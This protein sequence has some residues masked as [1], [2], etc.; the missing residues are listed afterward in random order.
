[1]LIVHVLVAELSVETT[2][3]ISPL[4]AGSGLEGMMTLTQRPL[5]EPEMPLD[6][7]WGLLNSLTAKV[8]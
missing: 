4:L 7:S 6:F 8:L 1:M 3:P 5:L 2:Q